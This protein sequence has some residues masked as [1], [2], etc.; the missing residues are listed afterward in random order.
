MVKH[1]ILG[2]KS[3]KLETVVISNSDNVEDA[4][5]CDYF[6]DHPQEPKKQLDAWLEDKS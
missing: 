3:G 6:V 4:T 5:N 2:F 1:F